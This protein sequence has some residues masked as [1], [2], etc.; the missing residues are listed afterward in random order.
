MARAAR[1][2]GR[3]LAP[4]ESSP[5]R[6]LT[7][8]RTPG[9]GRAPWLGAA[10]LL[11]I[12]TV[13]YLPSLRN[14]FVWDDNLHVQ[15]NLTLRSWEGLGRIWLDPTALPQYYPLVHTTFWVEYHLWGLEALGYHAVNVLLHALNAV[16][17]F[18]VLRRLGLRGALAAAALF[19]VHPVM[20]ESVGFIMERKNVL[21]TAF[22]LLALL[23]YLRF[24]PLT[25]LSAP[26]PGTARGRNW[27]MYALSLL[28]FL[29][30]LLSKTV[31]CTLPVSILVLGWWKQGRIPR[32]RLL[33]VTPM[34]ALGLA[35]GLM[36]VWLEVHHVGASGQEW[37]LG[38]T[39]RVLLAGRAPWFYLGK[40]L[41][42]AD[43]IFIYP[44]WDLSAAIWWQYL[45]PAA[46]V[47]VLAGLWLLRRRIGRGPLAAAVF[48]GVTLFPALGFLNYYPMRYSYVAD[49]FQ[50]LAAPGIFALAAGIAAGLM[51]RRPRAA[52]AGLAFL[53][54][55]LAGLGTLSWAQQE[56]YR[57]N[58]TLWRATLARDPGSWIA[59]NNLAADLLSRPADAAT[60]AEA[61]ALLAKALSLHPDFLDAHI[62]A[63]R[64]A[65]LKGRSGEA[66]RHYEYALRARPQDAELANSIGQTYVAAGRY[67][68]ALECFRQAAQR[69]PKLSKAHFNI[70]AL[71]EVVFH[72]RDQAILSYRSAI[73]A[74]PRNDEAHYRLGMCYAA[75][76]LT[77]E[78]RSEF[79]LALEIDPALAKAR[80]AMANLPQ[81]R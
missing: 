6:S 46:T 48:F 19:A 8:P 52:R 37:N 16:L 47:G 39:E 57:S 27:R 75:E 1:R 68:K 72:H 66:D 51:A 44:R 3:T 62:N 78:A 33:A 56:E 21:S 18:L 53:G 30:A 36:T 65:L 77:A 23:A 54:V 42:P 32:R 20:V 58:E 64:V 26:A 43:L 67:D 76:G 9:T 40:L 60:L 15:E 25:G 13:V 2:H 79:R 70:A 49:H 73:A 45:Y 4:G 55:L 24:D 71:E 50:Y 5:A 81:G 28:L 31:A 14:G 34:I 35:L 29:A 80:E 59:C 63:G 12:T 69:D 74:D 7:Q 61:D 17:V 22:Y 38:A 11:A 41:W 10:L